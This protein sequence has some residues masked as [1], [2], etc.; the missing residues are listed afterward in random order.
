MYRSSRTLAEGGDSNISQ[1]VSGTFW[2]SLKFLGVSEMKKDS[3][4]VF[5]R[6]GLQNYIKMVIL[7]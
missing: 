6:F 4:F 5:S 7:S 2:A 1:S 3:F